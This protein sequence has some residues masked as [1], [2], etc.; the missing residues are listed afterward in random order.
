[1]NPA[2]KFLAF[3]PER[4]NTV[5]EQAAIQR[6]I[7]PV[8][9]EKDFWVCWLLGVLYAE[10]ELA[11]HMVFKG[12]TS[13]SKAFGVIDRFSEDIDLS[14]A[15]AFVGADAEAFEK[16]TSRGK[17]DAAAA[18]MQVLC[19]EKTRSVIGPVLEAAIV[20]AIGQRAN[21]ETWLSF[22]E[23]QDAELPVLRFHY[24]TQQTDGFAYLPRNVK[25]ELGSLTDQQPIGQY[26]IRPWV[27]D[28]F[29][30]VFDDWQCKVTVLELERT[31]WEKATILHAEYHRPADQPMP[32]RYARHYAD[33]ARLLELDQA[34]AFMA[35]KQ[36][37]ERVVT[38]KSKVF[39]KASARYDLAKHGTFRL[40]PPPERREALAA[41]YATMRPMFLSDPAR[42]EDIMRQ[43]S[44]AEEHINS[45]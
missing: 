7:S 42:F 38:W 22:E 26:D 41:D 23:D 5:I 6:S 30:A 24:P 32:D 8:V 44:E 20:A 36:Q 16:L 37:C 31:F 43:L 28:V 2:A 25:L 13:L 14:V 21:G 33:L 1:V 11:P 27:A 45:M 15:P 9:M 12:G 17:R 40:V 3:A 35:D 19:V 29:P 34:K 10:P 18:Q 39:A 4:R